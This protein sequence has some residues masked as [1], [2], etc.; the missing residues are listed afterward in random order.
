MNINER[1]FYTS[2][3]SSHNLI[4]ESCVCVRVYMLYD[5]PFNL[6]MYHLIS[7]SIQ[8]EQS[9]YN[10]CEVKITRRT[11]FP[12]SFVYSFLP[13]YYFFTLCIS[14]RILYIKP[15]NE[16]ITHT[17]TIYVSRFKF[18]DSNSFLS[19]KSHNNLLFMFTQ[20]IIILL[21]SILPTL[22]ISSL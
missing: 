5:S 15:Y 11:S 14:Y 10:M 21:L 4:V 3:Y 19:H 13:L 20:K 2:S 8:N 12:Q 16:T 22:I 7:R 18:I 6:C 17:S 1:T 9:H